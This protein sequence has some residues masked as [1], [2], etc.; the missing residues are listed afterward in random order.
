MNAGVSPGVQIL[1]NFDFLR[2]RTEEYILCL[3]QGVGEEWGGG[4]GGGV[5]FLLPFI[6]Y[7][8]FQPIQWCPSHE[9]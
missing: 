9:K 1:Q 5:A 4:W 7:P 2:Q 6:F 3:R 8:G